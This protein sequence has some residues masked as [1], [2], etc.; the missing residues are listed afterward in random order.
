MTIYNLLPKKRPPREV[1]V[2]RPPTR[3]RQRVVFLLAVI[4]A[5]ISLPI[6]SYADYASEYYFGGDE[7]GYIK[8]SHQPT[9]K[10]PWVSI[11]MLLYDP[12][13]K[14]YFPQAPS[15]FID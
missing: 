1:D 9:A 11:R 15:V 2:S 5:A 10:E 6:K 14:I 4:L 13:N 3:M 7:N 8:V 12:T